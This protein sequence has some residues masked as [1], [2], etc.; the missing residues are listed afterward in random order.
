MREAKNSDKQLVINILSKSFDTNKSINYVVKQDAK[1]LE[2][3]K[4]LMEYSFFM[5]YN[6]GKVFIS[7]DNNSCAILIHQK[8][9]TLKSVLWDIKLIFNVIGVK[10][11][12]K[13][14]KREN[15]LKSI[16]PKEKFIHLW[17]LGV[18]PEFQSKGI[19]T[20][21]LNNVTQYYKKEQI[22]LETSTLSNLPFYKKNGFKIIDEIELDYKLFVLK[23]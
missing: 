15:K 23:K 12:L 19:G 6:F 17:Y 1:R 20:E 18:F 13:V 21:L 5:G 9:T 8:K 11:V 4:I 10:R 22:Y 16:Q 14:L 2:R 7:N 3:I